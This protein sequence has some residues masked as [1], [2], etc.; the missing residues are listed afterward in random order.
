MHTKALVQ[1]ML[2]KKINTILVK[3]AILS[4]TEI[5]NIKNLWNI[6][7][8]QRKYLRKEVFGTQ[9]MKFRINI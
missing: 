7:K 5:N 9:I 4:I 8:C 2:K 1:E 6:W 3:V